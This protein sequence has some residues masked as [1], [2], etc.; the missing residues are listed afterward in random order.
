MEDS[1][2]NGMGMEEAVMRLFQYASASNSLF[3]SG[4]PAIVI[5]RFKPSL[6]RSENANKGDNK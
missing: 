6:N 2:A 5:D 1:K 3:I 4:R